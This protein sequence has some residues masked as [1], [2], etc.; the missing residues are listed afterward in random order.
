MPPNASICFWMPPD[1]SGCFRMPP[2]ASGCFRM[3]PDASGCLRMP[4]DASR[5]LR[6]PLQWRN[7][8][9]ESASEESASTEVDSLSFLTSKFVR[10]QQRQLLL[11][12]LDISRCLPVGYSGFGYLP[13]THVFCRG[14]ALGGPK[15]VWTLNFF[16]R[17]GVAVILLHFPKHRMVKVSAGTSVAGRLAGFP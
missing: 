1:T 10:S 9:E 15:I 14:P 6:M 3:P 8:A 7:L 17:D 5:C 13:G 2:D 16:C 11:W 4:L 12:T